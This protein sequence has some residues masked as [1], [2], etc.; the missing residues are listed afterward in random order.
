[1][2]HQ[3]PVTYLPVVE[4][5][6]S[7]RAVTWQGKRDMRV[8][9]VPD[10]QIKEP[11]DAI[12]RVTTTGLCGSDLHLYEVLGPFMQAGDVVGH[13]PMGIVE[14]VGSGVPNLTVG[15]RVVIPFNVSCG[16][17]WMCEHRLQ[18]QCET[19]QNREHGTGASLF[20]YSKL[21]G[22]V[23]GGQAEYLRVP[24]ADYGAVKVPEGP[25]DDRFVFLSDVLPTAWQAVEYA[26]VPDGGSV[27]V[28]GAGPIG[29]MAA[30]IALHRGFQVIV[31]DLVPER[32]QRVASRGADVIN[33]ETIDKSSDLAEEVR[34]RTKGRGADSVIEAVGMEAHGSPGSKIAHALVGLLPDKLAEPLMLNAG[35][36]RMEA[37]YSAFEA[38]RRGGT[39]SISGVYGG[40]SDPIP[41]FQ[42]FDKQLQL[43]MG[44]ANVRAWTDDILEL[45]NQ[46][47]DVLGVESFATHH[48]PLDEAPDAYEKFQKKEDGMV[49]VVFN[50]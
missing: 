33:L 26:D 18:S 19:T 15:D 45:L 3:R 25:P 10:P 28:L 41:L 46:D 30:R 44:Q 12:I 21:Y 43:R 5:E 38:V 35:V 50:P 48:L 11:T 39:V 42:I 36:D 7:M 2:P 29:D 17:C 9:E 23:P 47:E 32:L 24:H 4:E 8:M 27:L 40:A 1:M 34:A 6:K 31:A 49:K 13:E 14:E 22:Q 20:G 37:L 16:H